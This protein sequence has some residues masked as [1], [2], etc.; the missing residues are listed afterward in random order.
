MTHLSGLIADPIVT[1]GE[2]HKLSSTGGGG[3]PSRSSLLN[4]W[5]MFHDISSCQDA[6]L[7]SSSPS[8]YAVDAANALSS[9]ALP[10]P[11]SLVAG[12]LVYDKI[13]PLS[14]PCEQE[15]ESLMVSTI[16]LTRMHIK[17]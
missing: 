4:Y 1:T 3:S 7:T 6:A 15:H 10:V 17:S 9:I 13:A 2:T 12:A 16:R 8:G 14:V 11:S 5:S